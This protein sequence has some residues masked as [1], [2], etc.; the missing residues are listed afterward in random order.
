MITAL[1]LPVWTSSKYN[2]TYPVSSRQT[3]CTDP[4][5]RAKKGNSLLIIKEVGGI[6]TGT[7]KKVDS[8]AGGRYVVIVRKAEKKHPDKHLLKINGNHS[9][10]L[11]GAGQGQLKS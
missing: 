9:T 7:Q 10:N 3:P 5:F 8:E 1:F 2:N 11:V 4:K 6:S